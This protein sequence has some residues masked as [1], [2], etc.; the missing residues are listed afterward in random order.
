MTSIAIINQSTTVSNQDVAT[1]TLACGFQLPSLCA[2]WQIHPVHIHFSESGTYGKGVVPIYILDNADQQGALGYHDEDANGNQ[3]GRIFAKTVLDNQGTVLTGQLS[4]SSV[5]SH[6]VME[7]AVDPRCNL[8][9]N[10]GG[11]MVALE[12]GDPVEADSYSIHVAGNPVSVSN[13]VLPSWFD[14][15]DASGLWDRMQNCGGPGQMSAGGYEIVMQASQVTQAFGDTQPEAW[16][17]AMKDAPGS[18]TSRRKTL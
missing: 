6:E 13:Y 12:V 16:R 3:Y 2:A 1:M 10:V 8:W 11:Q 9:A 17:Q 14:D 7:W 4:V 15:Q 18:R 5:L